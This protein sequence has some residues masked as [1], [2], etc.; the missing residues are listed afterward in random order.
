[1]ALTK[2]EIHE[3]KVIQ[4]K[5]FKEEADMEN[6]KETNEDDG[7]VDTTVTFVQTDSDIEI[8]AQGKEE[9]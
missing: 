9:G 7:T 3:A 6:D 5:K 8:N 1:M 2:E 4:E